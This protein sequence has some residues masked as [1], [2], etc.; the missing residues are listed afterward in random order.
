MKIYDFNENLDE[1]EELELD[2]TFSIPDLFLPITT[3][4]LIDDKTKCVWLWIGR[5]TTIRVKFLAAYK[6]STIRDK[7]CV[8]YKIKTVDQGHEP[9]K[10][11]ERFG[12]AVSKQEEVLLEQDVESFQ[13][14]INT[15]KLLMIFKARAYRDYT[16]GG[17]PNRADKYYLQWI[18]LCQLCD[19]LGVTYQSITE[20]G[21]GNEE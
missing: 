7:H 19:A 6:S 2:D 12:L 4:L 10:F 14:V 20:E 18:V 3:L 17:D 11:K 5:R 13:D 16:L 21:N 1:F 8:Y 9:K 15:I